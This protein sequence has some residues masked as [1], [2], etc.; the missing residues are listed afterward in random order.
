MFLSTK[1]AQD[2]MLLSASPWL[3]SS[4][5]RRSFSHDFAVTYI[6]D[7]TRWRE[8]MNIILCLSGKNNIS[9]VSEANE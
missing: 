3:V 8:D 6:E 1:L 2:T 7:I 4:V 5:H 9:R